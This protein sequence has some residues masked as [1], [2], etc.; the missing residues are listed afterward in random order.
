ML[1]AAAYVAWFRAGN[2]PID[3]AIGANRTVNELRTLLLY[4][5]ES[6]RLLSMARGFVGEEEQEAG[7]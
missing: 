3:C 1:W 2:M 7:R 4:G 5:D 6:E